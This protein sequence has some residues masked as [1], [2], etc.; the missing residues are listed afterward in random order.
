[1]TDGCNAVVPL[2]EQRVP[3]QDELGEEEE[4]HVRVTGSHT[5]KYTHLDSNWTRFYQKVCVC[6]CVRAC[7]RACVGACVRACVC[8]AEANMWVCY[9]GENM[10]QC[11]RSELRMF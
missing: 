1:M 6:A 11:Q 7:V 8:N 3:I 9:R 2:E 5:H 4:E 10:Q